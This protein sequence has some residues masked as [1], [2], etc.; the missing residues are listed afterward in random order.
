MP[1]FFKAFAFAVFTSYQTDF[2]NM[3]LYWY[4]Y[5]YVK[6]NIDFLNTNQIDKG[7]DAG[8]KD[9]SYHHL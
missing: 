7:I 6:S 9:V 3:S 5:S 1:L 8:K 2:L 4:M